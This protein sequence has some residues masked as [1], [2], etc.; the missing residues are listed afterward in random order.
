VDLEGAGEEKEGSTQG[1]LPS[2]KK[3]EIRPSTDEIELVVRYLLWWRVTVVR[4]GPQVSSHGERW[5][6]G[7]AA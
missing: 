5:V 1:L 4:G 2:R 7:V 6:L 3:P